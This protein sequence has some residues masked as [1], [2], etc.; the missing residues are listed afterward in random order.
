MNR[1][2]RATASIET[3]L[4]YYSVL[5]VVIARR[6]I[7]PAQRGGGVRRIFVYGPVLFIIARAPLLALLDALVRL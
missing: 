1:A 3:V 7:T 6:L 2:N 4:L 5:A